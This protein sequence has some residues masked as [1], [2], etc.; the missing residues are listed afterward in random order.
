MYKDGEEVLIKAKVLRVSPSIFGY[1][2]EIGRGS[3]RRVLGITEEIVLPGKTYEQGLSDAWELAK[4][5]YALEPDEREKMLGYQSMKAILKDL[6]AEY[7]ADAIE[8]HEKEKEIKV[9]DEVVHGC[10]G[11]GI[12]FYVTYLT[13]NQIKGFSKDGDTHYFILPNQYI[14]KTGKHIDIESLLRQIG[15]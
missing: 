10:D 2:C 9:G 12:K 4:K 14:K 6:S 5:V 11:C 8:T 1:E 3:N 15:E 7:V 13:Q